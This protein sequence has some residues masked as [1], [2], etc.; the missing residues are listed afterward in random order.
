MQPQ[1]R[2]RSDESEAT[3]LARLAEGD[4][5]AA[6]AL[7]DR[8]Y[9][10][11]YAALVRF[12]GGDADLAADLTQDTYRKAWQ[13]IAT[14]DGRSRL[15]T[16]LYRI[17]YTTFLNH[18]RRPA[19]VQPLDEARAERLEDPGTGQEERLQRR[20]AAERLRR[21]VLALPEPLR[22]TVTA[23]YWGDV[24]VR[25]LAAAEELTGAAVR[26]RLKTARERLRL[27]L[28]ETTR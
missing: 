28:E 10:D 18:V 26:K 17:A 23:H 6:E 14:F 16:W 27:D 4:R 1:P 15:G 21:A 20:R 9:G 19:L 7:V 2:P 25:E 11:V 13:S 5:R 8:T 3:L 24:P 22:F 12:T